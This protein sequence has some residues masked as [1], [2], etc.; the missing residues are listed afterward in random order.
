VI[1][2]GSIDMTIDTQIN[3]KVLDHGVSN[4]SLT[5][6]YLQPRWR[7]PGLFLTKIEGSNDFKVKREKMKS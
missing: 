6:K 2:V 4:E 5:S 1:K 7:F 3:H